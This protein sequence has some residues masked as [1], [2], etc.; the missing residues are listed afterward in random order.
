MK[1]LLTIAIP[2]FN[3]AERLDKSLNDLLE[4]INRSKKNQYISVFVSNNGSSDATAEVITKY[5]IQF[6]RNAILF[7]VN[8]FTQNQGFD[9]NVLACYEKS[10][11]DYVWFLSD[12]DNVINGGI[13]SIINDIEIFAPNVVY[14]NFDQ[15]PYNISNPYINNTKLYKEINHEG[16]Q[17]ISKIIEWPKLTSLVIKRKTLSK[18]GITIG[19]GFM[20]VALAIQVGL[21][22]GRVLHSV[23]YIAGPD[24]DYRDQINFPPYIGNNLYKML[25]HLLCVN[26][27]LEFYDQIDVKVVDPLTSSMNT[28]GAYYR[29]K[30]VLTNALK[31]ELLSTIKWELRN[32]GI[33]RRGKYMIAMSMVKLLISYACNILFLFLMGKNL[34]KTRKK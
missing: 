14:Y 24:K 23:K 6:E 33:K 21:S 13:N 2:T 30:F 26:H 32:L 27:K 1:T 25:R 4:Q 29:G 7:K 15:F 11:S 34:E 18:D 17:S 5:S 8:T 19:S 31:A 9:A 12:D 20:H 10:N 3:R 16:I 28:L 22:Y